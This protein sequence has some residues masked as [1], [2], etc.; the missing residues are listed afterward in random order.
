MVPKGRYVIVRISSSTTV[1]VG[2][3]PLQYAADD[4]RVI[5]TRTS[6]GPTVLEDAV[7]VILLPVL[8]VDELDGE[9]NPWC[10]G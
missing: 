10:H 6:G 4:D 9:P 8:T 7:L 5:G 3:D 1:S 2:A